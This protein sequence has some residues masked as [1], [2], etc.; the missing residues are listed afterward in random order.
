M[1]YEHRTALCGCEKK[2]ERHIDLQGHLQSKLEHL[3]D[4]VD[5]DLKEKRSKLVQTHLHH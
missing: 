4:V 5:I 1:K 2:A 3:D